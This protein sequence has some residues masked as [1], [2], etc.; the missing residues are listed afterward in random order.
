M[1]TKFDPVWWAAEEF[2]AALNELPPAKVPARQPAAS[3]RI[4]V[5]LSVDG[6]ARVAALEIVNVIQRND[7]EGACVPPFE[8]GPAHS[9]RYRFTSRTGWHF[10]CERGHQIGDVPRVEGSPVVTFSLWWAP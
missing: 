7:I 5:D 6:A 3:F 9:D 4:D 8:M 2:F 1:T 10:G